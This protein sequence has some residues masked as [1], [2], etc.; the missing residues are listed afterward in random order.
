MLL[1]LTRN[2]FTNNEYKVSYSDRQ[3]TFTIVDETITSSI[4]SK[5]I[6]AIVCTVRFFASDGSVDRDVIGSLVVGIGDENVLVTSTK[7]ELRGHLMNQDTMADCTVELY[8]S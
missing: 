3:A 2:L 7:P 8:E 4:G 5:A 6:N 1:V